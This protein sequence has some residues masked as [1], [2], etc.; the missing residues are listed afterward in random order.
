M[1][2]IGVCL[3]FNGQAEEAA[4]YY[5]SVFKNSKMGH[6]MRYDAASAKASGQPEGSVLTVSFQ[7]EGIEFMGLN[8]GS[9]FKFS[10]ATS[11]VMTCKDQAEIDYYWSKLSAVPQAEQ[12]G[13]CKDKFGVSWQIV[14]EGLDQMLSN[15]AGMKAMISMKK[16]VIADLKNAK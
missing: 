12:C 13:W 11:F 3:W 4:N 8:G 1:S 6:T 15:P 7:L 16:L 10:E 14:P 5:C 2:K 9:N